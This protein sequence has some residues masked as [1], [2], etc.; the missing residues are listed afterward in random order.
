MRMYAVLKV[1]TLAANVS[2]TQS[3]ITLASGTHLP[4]LDTGEYLIVLVNDRF[5]TEIM[6]CTAIAGAVLTV[7]R[8]QKDDKIYNFT[9]GDY[10]QISIDPEGFEF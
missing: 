8:G 1:T 7:V 3:T 6:H 2:L 10:V 9:S 5:K 4:T